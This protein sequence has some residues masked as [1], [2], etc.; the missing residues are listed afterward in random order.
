MNLRR[1]G[2][3]FIYS[4]TDEEAR[5]MFIGMIRSVEGNKYYDNYHTLSLDQLVK[6]YQILKMAEEMKK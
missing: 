4:P 2:D 5:Q 3:K 6:K 1:E